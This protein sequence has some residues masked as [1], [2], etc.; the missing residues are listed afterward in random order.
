MRYDSCMSNQPSLLI[1]TSPDCPN[2]TI[3]VDLAQVAAMS[4]RPLAYDWII[5]C[6][7]VAFSMP[8]W[9]GDKVHAA[10]VAFRGKFNPQTD[11]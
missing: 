4:V 8:S 1:V 2:R 11:R 7:G 5:T 9:A 10:W 6:G 3:T